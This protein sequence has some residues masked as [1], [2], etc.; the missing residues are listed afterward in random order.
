[1]LIHSCLSD[2]SIQ[3]GVRLSL[4]S[5]FQ[6]QF[7]LIVRQFGVSLW[8]VVRLFYRYSEVLPTTFN[9]SI[10]KQCTSS[11]VVV[12]VDVAFVFVV[13]FVVVAAAAVVRSW[14]LWLQ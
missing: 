8:S 6:Q 9:I 5:F 4:V 10:I 2:K 14:G 1:M 7:M 12:V 11:H 13:F 3:L